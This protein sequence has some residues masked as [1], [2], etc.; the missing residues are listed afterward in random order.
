M[1]EA[2][3][4]GTAAGQGP[5]DALLD[6]QQGTGCVEESPGGYTMVDV[7]HPGPLPGRNRLH[8]LAG[9]QLR[10]P[11]S[12]GAGDP[13]RDGA[14]LGRASRGDR[15]HGRV[16]LTLGEL[17]TA[18]CPAARSTFWSSSPCSPRPTPPGATRAGAV[19]SRHGASRSLTPAIW[20]SAERTT[21][22]LFEP[23]VQHWAIDAGWPAEVARWGYANLHFK[24]SCLTA[25]DPLLRL[26]GQLRVRPEHGLR[27]DGDLA[28]RLRALP[29][30]TAT[31][32]RRSWVS[33]R[34][35]R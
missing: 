27:R 14:V 30:R 17:R 6:H 21:G 12:P 13:V 29:D 25:R 5:L 7:D 35:A 8:P 23:S 26:S 18:S 34:R 20:S 28:D 3:K 1:L 15:P 11:L 9:G 2:S 4:P 33:T 10:A 19:D 22:L 32:H 16:A 24:G 31:L